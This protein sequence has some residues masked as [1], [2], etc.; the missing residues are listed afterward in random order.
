[1]KVFNAIDEEPIRSEQVLSHPVPK[2]LYQVVRGRSRVQIVAMEGDHL[3]ASQPATFLGPDECGVVLVL[4]FYRPFTP[5][6]PNLS[7]LL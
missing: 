5:C 4:P 6:L 2:F 3:Y 1:M 7:V